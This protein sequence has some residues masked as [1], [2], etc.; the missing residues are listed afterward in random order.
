MGSPVQRKSGLSRER[1]E[2]AVSGGTIDEHRGLQ[3]FMT[4]FLETFMVDGLLDPRLRELVVLRIGWLC[5]QPYEWGSHYRVANGL[6]VSD[7]DVLAVRTGPTD[8]RFGPTE[9]ALLTA[10][11]EIM[12]LGRITEETYGRCRTALGDS[13]VLAL[14]LLYLATGYRM[15]ASIL[16][17]NELSLTEA[18]LELWPPDGVGPEARSTPN[19]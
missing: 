7:D 19:G 15:I 13:E 5:E 2:R 1:A 3:K 17:T 6:G 4:C 11:D 9:Q 10:A 18:G 16:S 8:P 14:E 12:E